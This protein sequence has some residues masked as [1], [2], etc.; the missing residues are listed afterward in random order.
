MIGRLVGRYR[1]VSKI[2][3]GGMGVIYRARD[4]VLNRDVA[5]K[6]LAE[7]PVI[8]GLD[9][10][11]LLHEARAGSALNHPNICTVYEILEIDGEL[12]FV[13]ELIEGKSLSALIGDAGL[14]VES[15]LRY[16]VQIA[17][18]LGHAHGR[19][20][21]H[22]DLK[23]SNIVVTTD[24]LVKV[25][26][27]GLAR[28]VAA[29]VTD[30]SEV[31]VMSHSSPGTVSGTL[32]YMAPEVLRGAPGDVAERSVGAWRR[33]LRGCCRPASVSR[34]DGLR[35][36]LCNPARNAAAVAG[37]NP[38]ELVGN[39]SAMP[40]EGPRAAVPERQRSQGGA[41]RGRVGSDR[42]RSATEPA[43]GFPDDGHARRPT[44]DRQRQRCAAAGRH[45]EGRISSA[46]DEPALALGSRGTLLSWARGL[47]SGV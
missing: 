27:F 14:P 13:M 8:E 5:L 32:S 28:R 4:E 25:L 35:D 24:G 12:Y 9:K 40:R 43:N 17:A 41:R 37:A 26:D 21:I 44:L 10:D 2:G 6:V 15:V 7:S 42:R 3:E 45:D 22:R 11:H 20:I 31:T 16:G 19:G 46:L 36:E 18:A 47:R 34:E 38:S 39:D 30:E 33:P 1:I 23:S 29:D